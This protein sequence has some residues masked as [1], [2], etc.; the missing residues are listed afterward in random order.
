MSKKC[1]NCGSSNYI[2]VPS[3]EKCSDCGIQCNYH[4]S[5]TNE[6]Y[7]A[8]MEENQES[9]W[10]RHCREMDEEAKMDEDGP[11]WLG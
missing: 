9:D 4:G 8:A 3:R 5:G 10:E 6:K 1:W 2:D 11:Y 7:K